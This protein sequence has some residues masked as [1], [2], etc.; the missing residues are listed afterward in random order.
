VKL[1]VADLVNCTESKN[2]QY[3]T[4]Q[5][6]PETEELFPLLTG[7]MMVLELLPGISTAIGSS[8]AI[9]VQHQGAQPPFPPCLLMIVRTSSDKGG[10][11]P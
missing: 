7:R 11:S 6:E 4:G 5:T 9:A 10:L 3:S 8:M 1:N 2:A